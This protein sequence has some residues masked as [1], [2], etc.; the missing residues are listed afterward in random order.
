MEPCELVDS[1]RASF[2]GSACAFEALVSS[3]QEFLF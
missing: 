3:H 2:E 1:T